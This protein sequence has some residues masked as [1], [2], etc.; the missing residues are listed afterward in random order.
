MALF[1]V[2][3]LL[4]P[5]SLIEN[6]QVDRLIA[7]A[8]A[9]LQSDNLSR[10]EDLFK[11]ASDRA[12]DLWEA[13]WGLSRV[14]FRTGDFAE[15]LAQSRKVIEKK[16]QSN[17]AILP[18]DRYQ[19][20]LALDGIGETVAAL[21]VL[22][23]IVK[24]ASPTSN[25]YKDAIFDT[26]LLNLNLA[27]SETDEARRSLL[28]EAANKGFSGYAK[29]EDNPTEWYHYHRAC[30]AASFGDVPDDRAQNALNEFKLAVDTIKKLPRELSRNQAE[31]MQDTLSGRYPRQPGYPSHC[32]ALVALIKQHYP[33]IES[34]FTS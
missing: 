7:P 9:A 13:N 31:I 2:V 28:L 20:A 30:I 16:R 10:A 29:V 18:Q 19:V 5:P 33:T 25:V 27:L 15:A 34:I 1:V 23:E 6:R 11:T 3:F 4:N 12:P 24:T 26:G 14:A 22:S 21:G 32:P 8:E 17:E